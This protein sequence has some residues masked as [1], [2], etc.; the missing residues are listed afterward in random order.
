MFTLAWHARL[1][2]PAWFELC[3]TEHVRCTSH[4]LAGHPPSHSHFLAPH[5]FLQTTLH[6]TLLELYL[7]EHLPDQGQT[8]PPPQP[9]PQPAP[10][11]QHKQQRQQQRAKQKEGHQQQQQ[12]QQQKQHADAKDRAP[13]DM[14]V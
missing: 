5:T 11:Q 13:M 9:H 6:H 2:S 1:H 12:Q 4:F 8:P 14:K 3:L 7:M 10:E